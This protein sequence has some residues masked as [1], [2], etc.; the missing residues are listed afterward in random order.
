M[1]CISHKHTGRRPF[2]TNSK[3][4]VISGIYQEPH[5]R[6]T[7]FADWHWKQSLKLTVGRIFEFD[8]HQYHAIPRGERWLLQLL[9]IKRDLEYMQASQLPLDKTQALHDT[10]TI[11]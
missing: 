8:N 6:L 9:Y 7:V 10:L 1:L 2:L 3:A 11:I 4:S 5:E